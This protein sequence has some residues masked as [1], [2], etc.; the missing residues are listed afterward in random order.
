MGL[1]LCTAMKDYSRILE[2]SKRNN[3]QRIINIGAESKLN[4]WNIL[5]LIEDMSNRMRTR[6]DSVIDNPWKHSVSGVNLELSKISGKGRR[7]MLKAQFYRISNSEMTLKVFA[8]EILSDGKAVKVARAIY[9]IN[10]VKS[11]QDRAA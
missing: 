1:F 8:H 2:S 9:Q 5:R 10:V 7:L 11:A 3:L 4:E 6:L